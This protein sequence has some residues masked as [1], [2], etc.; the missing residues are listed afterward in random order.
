VQN[1]NIFEPFSTSDH[2]QVRFNVPLDTPHCRPL[3]S[4]S[5]CDFGRA[6]WAQIKLFLNNVDFY[7]VFN[8]DLPAHDIINNFY[9]IINDCIAHHVPVS[10]RSFRTK[11]RFMFYPYSVRKSILI[12][13]HKRGE[14]VAYLGGAAGAAAPPIIARSV[15]HPSIA[16]TP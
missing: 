6:D 16:K 9:D 7:E 15:A 3:R 11:S 13:N 14:P 1:I 2:S 8:N 12:E 4:H 5:V 10:H